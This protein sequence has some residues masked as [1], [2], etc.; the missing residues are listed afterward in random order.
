ML[1]EPHSNHYRPISTLAAWQGNYN[2]N[3]IEAIARS[4]R[5]FGFNNALRV[6]RD[7]VIAAGNHSF[8]ALLLIQEQ[9]AIPDLDLQ[10]P[11][12]NIIVQD[13]EWYVPFVDVSFLDETSFK[14]FA[15]ADNELARQATSDDELLAQYLQEILN[16]SPKTFEA[17]GFTEEALDQL[18]Q[19]IAAEAQAKQAAEDDEDKPTSDGS[20]L[21]LTQ[22]TIADPRHQ[23]ERGDVWLLGEHV[24]VCADVL[25]DWRAWVGFLKGES[26]IFAPY[27]GPFVPLTN[28]AETMRFVMVQPD[29]YIAGHILDRYCDVKGEGSVRKSA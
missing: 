4:I 14:A 22:V 21:A 6:W 17:T 28:K 11:P 3:D 8:K 10:F 29:P 12:A 18:L 25:K 1:P 5:R 2:R 19:E 7:D 16:E 26:T 23:V 27:P 24:L 15:V 13:G 9:G 20:L